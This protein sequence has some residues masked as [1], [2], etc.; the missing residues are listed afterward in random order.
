MRS[1][2]ARFILEFIQSSNPTILNNN[3]KKIWES[4]LKKANMV[5]ELEIER[6]RNTS[7]VEYYK[8]KAKDVVDEVKSE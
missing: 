7:F 1:L 5:L 2:D 4:R 8:N 3:S 6:N